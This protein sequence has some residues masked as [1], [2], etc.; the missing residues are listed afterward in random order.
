[1]TVAAQHNAERPGV[2]AGAFWC[3]TSRINT[4]GPVWA[5]GDLN[6]HVC[7]DTRT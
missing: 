6:P 2:V 5:E 3:Q 7:E 4:Y 1:M